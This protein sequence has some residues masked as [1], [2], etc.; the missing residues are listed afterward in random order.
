MARLMS[1]IKGGYY[2]ADPAAVAA[3]L[4]RL[5][6]PDAGNCLILDPCAGE[7]HALLQLAQGLH[8][9]PYGIELSEDRA[10]LVRESL[11]EGQSL[12]PADFLR[13]SISYRSFSFIWCNPPYDY[14]T[15]REGRVESQF[16]ERAV[17]L[18]VDNGVLALVCPHDVADSYQTSEFFEQWCCDISAMPLPEEVRKFNETVILGRRRKQPRT[19][20]HRDCPYDWLEKR[21]E[22]RIVYKLPPGQQPR[23]FRK[24][25]PTD[26][27]LA[28]LVLQSPLRFHIERPADKLN[29]RPRPPM[30][31]GI[32]H[33]A[34]LLAS[35]HIDGL[36]CPPNEPPHV[37]R[38]T[39]AKDQYVASCDENEGEDGSVT[40]RTVI[41]ERTR[42]VVRILDSEGTLST[43]E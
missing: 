23:H 16:I 24:T 21:M 9:V 12:A 14:A 8:A 3:V 22:D 27:E 41:S 29:Y 31:P 7:G 13:C 1:Q 15:G 35:G 38:G 37:I 36:I 28:R 18:L 2:A 10:A 34:M 6:P 33:R 19:V 39:A 5:R 32:G 4:D 17:Q 40:T 43:L 25:E 20:S 11:P 42:L 30:S 26:S